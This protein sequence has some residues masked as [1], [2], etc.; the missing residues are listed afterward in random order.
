VP[1]KDPEAQKRF[2]QQ[3]YQDNKAL[4]KSRARAWNQAHVQQ[5]R[6]YVQGLKANP[7]TD[8]GL[9]YP[10]Y[11]MQFDHLDPRTKKYEIRELV[12][13]FHSFSHLLAE[14]EKCELVCANCHAERTHQR[15]L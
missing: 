7:C 1:Y 8:C 12:V 5:K 11:V 4:Y 2:Q 13:S 10:Y 6:E 14:I 3:H 15:R 9:S